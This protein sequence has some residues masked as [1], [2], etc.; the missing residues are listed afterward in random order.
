VVHGDRT[1]ELVY[2]NGARRVLGTFGE[3]SEDEA[4]RADGFTYDR[5]NDRYFGVKK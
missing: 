4:E 2:S 3:I 1:F 5:D